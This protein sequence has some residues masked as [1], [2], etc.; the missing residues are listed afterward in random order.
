MS[1]AAPQNVSP[2]SGTEP[3]SQDASTSD[4]DKTK[5]IS[6]TKRTGLVIKVSGCKNA[7]IDKAGEFR[8][9]KYLDVACAAVLQRILSEFLVK[10]ANFMA[11]AHTGYTKVTPGILMEC[12]GKTETSFS[13]FINTSKLVVVG[14]NRITSPIFL[15]GGYFDDITVDGEPHYIE[16]LILGDLAEKLVKVGKK[17]KKLINSLQKDL[18]KNDNERILAALLEE[19]LKLKTAKRKSKAKPKHRGVSKSTKTS[20]AKKEKKEEARGSS[21][22]KKDRK[23]KEKEEEEEDAPEPKASKKRK[24]SE[25]SDKLDSKKS[26]TGGTKHK[27]KKHKSQKS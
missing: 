22:T 4:K 5:K 26:K 2:S 12:L 17:T 8:Q 1:T 15:G 7:L 18:D 24:R 27:D 23:R 16:P 10:L 3:L 6:K 9:A 25:S 11:H 20:S 21:S 14:G 19:R 13:K